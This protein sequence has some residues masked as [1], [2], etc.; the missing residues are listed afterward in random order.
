[1]A[2]ELKCHKE[3]SQFME[4]QF[5]ENFK[6]DE[7]LVIESVL[8]TNLLMVID[9]TPGINPPRYFL[10]PEKNGHE[11]CLVLFA[12]LANEVVFSKSLINGIPLSITTRS[13]GQG[14]D[15]LKVLYK[16][17]VAKNIYAP[18]VCTLRPRLHIK[19]SSCEKILSTFH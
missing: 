4:F 13:G 19:A 18:A 3:V 14:S 10:F 1:M 9:K 16:W 2:S 12:P 6:Y 15:D 5:G 8:G 17:S 11:I 7:N